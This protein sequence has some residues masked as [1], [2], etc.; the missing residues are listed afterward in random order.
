MWTDLKVGLYL[1][2]RS[3]AQATRSDPIIGDPSRAA[4]LQGWAREDV[5]RLLLRGR[6][7]AGVTVALRNLF[8]SVSVHTAKN[9]VL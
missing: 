8:V 7:H 2:V 4:V 3:Y 9:R 1:L 6:L 5:A